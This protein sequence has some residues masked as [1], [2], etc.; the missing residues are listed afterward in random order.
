MLSKSDLKFGIFMPP[1]H[2]FDENPTACFERDLQVIEH[3]DSLGFDEAWIGEHHSAGAELISSP[4]VFIAAA[5]ARTRHIKLGT[6]VTSLPYHHPLI[7]ADRWMQLHHMTRGRVMFGAGPGSLVS[8]ANMMGIPQEKLR[9]RMEESLDCIMRLIRGEVVT[10][11]TEWFSL[12]EGQLQLRPY[13]NIIPD[14]CTASMVS[15]SGP[16]AAG[17]FGTGMLSIGATSKE[18][19]ASA[20]GNWQIA[21]ETA[22]QHG[23]VMDRSKWRMVGMMHIAETREQAINDVNEGLKFFLEY[24]DTIGTLPLVPKEGRS[25]PARHMMESGVAVFGTPDDALEQIDKLWNSSGGGFGSFLTIDT[26]WAPFPAKLRS[27]ELVARYVMPKVQ[28]SNDQRY[29][30]ARTASVN[31][32]EFL[33]NHERAIQN[34]FDRLAAE[35]SKNAVPS[36]V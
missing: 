30:S 20:A 12:N 21:E 23:H 11:S 7:V 17:R 6:G 14:I 31:R 15:P 10:R 18:A 29:S 19:L 13:K 5:A 4:E 26:N 34:E 2:H 28:Q 1:I 8:D 27:Y 22:A 32:S 24:F 36:K 25:D 16:R 35:R 9:P 3:L 33:G